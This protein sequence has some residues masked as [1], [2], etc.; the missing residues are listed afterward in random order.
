MRCR[1][2]IRFLDRRM[3]PWDASAGLLLIQ[4]AGGRTAAYPGSKGLVAGGEVLAAA[5]GIY[6][7]INAL[8]RR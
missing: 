2:D 1:V 3:H 8:I 6:D 5:P 7:A 4:E